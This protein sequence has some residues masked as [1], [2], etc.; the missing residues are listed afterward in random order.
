M[1][2]A[3]AAGA[4]IGT[5]AT[6]S[7]SS[8]RYHPGSSRDLFQS[9]PIR[10][11]VLGRCLVVVLVPLVSGG[12]WYA[13]K[14]APHRQPALSPGVRGLGRTLCAGWYGPGGHADE[15]VLHAVGDWGALSDILW[16]SSTRGS[17]RSGRLV[18]RGWAVKVGEP[19]RRARIGIFSILAVLNVA[20]YWL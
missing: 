11:K 9:G 20:L 8:L 15:S 2:G 12:Y 1:I 18:G 6:G 3:L 5:K 4:A 13:P 19:G 10:I 7:C 17:S 14:R 16:P